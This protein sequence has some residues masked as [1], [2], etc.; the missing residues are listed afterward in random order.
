MTSKIRSMQQRR[1]SHGMTLK[2][3]FE[4]HNNAIRLIER[5]LNYFTVLIN[6]TVI[7]NY[8]LKFISLLMPFLLHL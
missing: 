6:Y 3:F 4:P 2:P 1:S 7:F 5:H 8:S